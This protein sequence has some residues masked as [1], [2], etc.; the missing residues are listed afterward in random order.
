[1][2]LGFGEIKTFGRIPGAIFLTRGGGLAGLNTLLGERLWETLGGKRYPGV[3]KGGK[4]GP[5]FGGEK[6]T[7]G[8]SAFKQDTAAF[9]ALY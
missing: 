7:K 9:W 5:A 3:K 6:I 2:F 1:M 4:M 8:G